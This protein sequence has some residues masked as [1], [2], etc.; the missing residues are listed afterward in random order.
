MQVMCHAGCAWT[1][2]CWPALCWV[3][4]GRSAGWV[5]GVPGH[6]CATRCGQQAAGGGGRFLGGA[7]RGRAAAGELRCASG[8]ARPGRC[9]CDIVTEK[10][11]VSYFLWH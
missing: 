7:A 8:D 5:S 1:W 4:D 10:N 11:Y 3:G 2:R 6:T 9:A